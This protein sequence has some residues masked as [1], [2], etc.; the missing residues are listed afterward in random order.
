[1]SVR[2]RFRKFVHSSAAHVL[3]AVL[4]ATLGIVLVGVSVMFIRSMS[5]FS[6]ALPLPHD[7]TA[8]SAFTVA[9]AIV[10]AHLTGGLLLVP[11]LLTHVA[12][13][14]QLPILIGALAL[15][16]YS[17]GYFAS[18]PLWLTAAVAA[19]SLLVAIVGGGRYSIDVV[20]QHEQEKQHAGGAAA[21][22]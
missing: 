6:R 12:A 13:A 7:F 8:G 3:L 2:R 18:I 1:M 14:V 4:R 5:D 19:G 9:H 11:G 17:V 20:L 22:V 10:L 21:R 16:D 15:V